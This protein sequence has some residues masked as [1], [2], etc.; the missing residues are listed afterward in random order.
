MRK[1]IYRE[2]LQ[3]LKES[4][5]HF[6]NGP[7]NDMAIEFVETL[8]DLGAKQINVA[9]YE[10]FYENEE[11]FDA[12]LFLFLPPTISIEVMMEIVC[13][14]PDEISQEEDGSIRLWWD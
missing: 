5:S 4:G 6:A 9:L 1:P 10:D 3:Y 14:R 13:M 12:E 11:I 7:D 2:A 8:Y